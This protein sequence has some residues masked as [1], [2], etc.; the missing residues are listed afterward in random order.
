[1]FEL[2]IWNI[3]CLSLLLYSRRI[4]LHVTILFCLFFLSLFFFSFHLILGFPFNRTRCGN[5]KSDPMRCDACLFLSLCMENDRRLRSH[6]FLDMTY[7]Y[8]ACII[9]IVMMP[10]SDHYI[11]NN[12]HILFCITIFSPLHINLFDI[13]IVIIIIT[14][15]HKQ[16][17]CIS[18]SRINRH[19]NT[20]SLRYR[21]TD[22]S[23]RFRL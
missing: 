14:Y 12:E 17:N 22:L 5:C 13:V 23:I 3:L 20:H 6:N 4:T 2:T 1:M 9:F 18:F 8:Q 19:T 16:D 11:S 15:T 21:K 10:M 7:K